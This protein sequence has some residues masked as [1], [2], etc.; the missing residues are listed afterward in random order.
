MRRKIIPFPIGESLGIYEKYNSA[1]SGK[2]RLKV[3]YVI[4]TSSLLRRQAIEWTKRMPGVVRGRKQGTT[5]AV[6]SAGA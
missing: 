4:A 5:R 1:L 6:E 2:E 3:E